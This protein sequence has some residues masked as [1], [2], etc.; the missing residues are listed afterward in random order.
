L[1]TALFALAKEGSAWSAGSAQASSAKISAMPDSGIDDRDCKSEQRV[2]ENSQ[3][4]VWLPGRPKGQQRAVQPRRPIRHT[5]ALRLHRR[6][7]CPKSHS[8][9]KKQKCSFSIHLKAETLPQRKQEQGRVEQPLW[10]L[11][12]AGGLPTK[13]TRIKIRPRFVRLPQRIAAL[14]PHDVA[15]VEP[16]TRPDHHNGGRNRSFAALWPNSA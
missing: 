3:H 9:W 11:R 4:Q 1:S 2:S 13:R 7:R 8:R 6:H 5:K 14:L 12:G 15:T 10:S 16:T